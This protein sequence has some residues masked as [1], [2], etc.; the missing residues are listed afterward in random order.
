MGR[1]RLT[2]ACR[3]SETPLFESRDGGL[4]EARSD[5]SGYG[6]PFMLQTYYPERTPDEIA[7]LFGQGFVDGID[8]LE[9]RVWHGPVLSGYG[10][11]LVYIHARVEPPEPGFEDHE[12]QVRADWQDAHRRE[13]NEAQFDSLLDRYDIVI[14]MP[15]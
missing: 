6:D 3:R 14:E 11:H 10:V 8:E 9:A 15:E 2:L 7:K 1:D 4:V 13:V 12:E 5:L